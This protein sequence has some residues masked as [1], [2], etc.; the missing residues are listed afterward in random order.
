MSYL[1]HRLDRGRLVALLVASSCALWSQS[2]AVGSIAMTVKAPGGKALPGAVITLDAGRGAVT[3]TSDA[4][5]KFLFQNLL[6]GAVKIK[7]RAKDLA[8][9][10]LPATVYVNQTTA[11]NVTLRPVVGATIVVVESMTPEVTTPIS[12]AVNGTDYSLDLIHSLPMIGDPLTALASLTPGTPSSGFNYN[13]SADTSNNFVVDGAEARSASGGLQNI[14]VNRDL[15]EQIQVLQ[16]GVSAKYG[17]F[18]GALFNTVTKSGTN[19]MAGSMTHELT[20]NSWNALPRQSD[21]TKSAEV[22][23]HVLDTQSWTLLGPIIQDKLFYAIG[24][25]VQTPAA[26][27]VYYSSLRSK[28]FPSFTFTRES[29]NELKDIKLDWQVNQD[30]RLSFAYNKY[31]SGANAGSSG[32]GISTFAATGGPSKTEK[33]FWTFGYTWVVAPDLNLDAKYSQTT[34]QSGGP[35]TGSPGGPGVVTWVDKSPAGSGD[36]YDNGASS[37]PLSQERIRT[38]GLNLTWFPEKHTVEAGLQNYTSRAISTGTSAPDAGY[39]GRTPSN[40]EIWFDGFT[41][42]PTSMDPANRIMV[43]NNNLLTRLVAFFPL[44]GQVDLR[45]TGLYVNDVW[46]PVEKLSFN[47]GARF[48][49]YHYTSTPDDSHFSF[50]SFTP[51]LG[52]FYDLKDDNQ[53]VFGITYSEYAGLMSTGAVSSASVTGNVPVNMYNYLGS[54]KGTDAL[55]PDGSINWSVWGK[56][57]GLTGAANPYFSSS[58][59]VSNAKYLVDP[60]LKAPRSRELI[61]TYRYNDTRQSLMI[62]LQRKIMD[63]YVDDIWQ[64]VAGTPAGQAIKLLSNDPGGKSTYTA[65]EGQYRNRI[66]EEFSTGANF[67]W[68]YVNSNFYDQGGSTS[69]RNNFGG[70][71]PDGVLAPNGLQGGQAGS[72]SSPFIAHLDTTYTHSFGKFGKLDVSLV[73]NYWAHSFQGYRTFTGPTSAQVQS[74]GY[75]ATATRQFYDSPEY[76]PEQYRFDFHLGYE[77]TLYKKVN[78]FTALDVTNFFNHMMAYY[79]NHTSSLLVDSTGK[80]YPNNSTSGLPAD[81]LTNPAYHVVASVPTSGS[82]DGSVGD[83]SAPRKVQLKLGIRF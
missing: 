38:T 4:D 65:L 68:S 52:A 26:T 71:I 6:P 36:F 73:G 29:F 16:G 27:T 1:N 37:S 61:G 13:G 15:I 56:A 18:V 76:W 77:V 69:A 78:F 54:G 75:A 82:L 32:Q 7:V 22:P 11:L 40:Y 80:T 35:G 49:Q 46:K 81:W 19:E 23:R 12:T 70:L 63:R 79:I 17:R 67:T 47:L 58:N 28:L 57:P 3:G 24:Y 74:L 66:T 59:P 53:H 48:D 51:R 14:S 39:L 8:D 10:F 5:G 44:T 72:D 2:S 30:Q 20:S 41:P 42:S 43:S 64:G 62:S 34:T 55:N 21:F 33:G 60:N 45:V 9:E 31:K 83:Y 50:N 25:Q